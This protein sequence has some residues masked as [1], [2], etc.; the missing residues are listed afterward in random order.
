MAKYV[1]D[2]HG[3]GGTRSRIGV[4]KEGLPA[5]GRGPAGGRALAGRRG[6]RDGRL[7]GLEGR[8]PKPSFLFLRY[9]LIVYSVFDI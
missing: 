6:G 9:L 8:R 5:R 3:L 7:H 2:F 4:L 1:A